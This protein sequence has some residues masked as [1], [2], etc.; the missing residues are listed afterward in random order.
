MNQEISSLLK[1]ITLDGFLSFGPK[2]VTVPLTGLNMIIGPNGS[3]K[4]NFIEAISVLQAVPRDLPLPI[5]AGGGVR[6]W[7]WKGSQPAERAIIEVVF[8]EGTVVHH[9]VHK[10]AVRYRLTFGTEGE[11]FTVL[12]ERVEDETAA[13]GESKPYFYFGYENGQP[14]L[15]I[16]QEKRREKRRL[17]REDIDPTQSILSQRRDPESY[18]E[19]TRVADF[20]RGILV[21][22]SW[23]FGPNSTLRMS[24]A[25]DVRTDYLLED[26]SNLP[27]RLAVLKRAPEVKK[28][29]IEL[30]GELA[31]GFDDLEIVPEGGQLQL[32]L[33]ENGRMFPARRLS[34]GS[35]R[36]LCL[37]AILLD[38]TPR[39]LVVIEEPELGLHPDILP[40][41]RDLM[42]EAC[43]TRQLIITTHSTQLLDAMT[44][45][46]ASVLICEKEE[47][48]TCLTRLSQDE[49]EQWREHGGLGD[50]WMSG[51]IGGTRW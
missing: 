37:L 29:I 31:P 12:D 6:D 30:L 21:Y 7:L 44:D 9:Q 5:R 24:C 15:N 17:Q 46:A 47:G 40:T 34:D 22:R 19:V 20:L 16:S 4:S 33:A 32:Y 1:S 36:F 18:P 39:P 11:L 45:H 25:P 14:M 49:I 50:L 13:E 2:A 26:F 43:E 27:A 42:V 23:S 38:P 8:R 51:H 10:P 28:R 41:I 48:S 35:L 3:G